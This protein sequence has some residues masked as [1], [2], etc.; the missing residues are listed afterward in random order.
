MDGTEFMDP[1]PPAAEEFEGTVIEDASSPVEDALPLD[2]SSVPPPVSRQVSVAECRREMEL[3]TESAVCRV[4]QEL[5]LSLARDGSTPVAVLAAR[6]GE[7]PA[8]IS[9][10]LNRLKTAG[11]VQYD[12]KGRE[13]WYEVTP[14]VVRL[15]RK[16]GLQHLH[17]TRPSGIGVTLHFPDTG[18]GRETT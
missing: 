7:E 17:I 2:E 9:H 11:L 6:I 15:E 13:K 18:A 14:G 10:H 5:M 16:N 8:K 12:Q 1:P 4:R 3:V